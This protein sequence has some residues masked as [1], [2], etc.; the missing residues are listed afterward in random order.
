MQV[1]IV[2][3][4]TGLIIQVMDK[5][6]VAKWLKDNNLDKKHNIYYRTKGEMMKFDVLLLDVDD[7]VKDSTN[8]NE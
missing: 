8:Q 1:S 3:M 2:S 4:S 5:V 6:D 7:V